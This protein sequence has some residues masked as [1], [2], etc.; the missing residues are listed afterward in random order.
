MSYWGHQC[1]TSA[2]L[3]ARGC[4][5]RGAFIFLIRSVVLVADKQQISNMQAFKIYV[6]S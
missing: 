1:A 5:K 3:G 6:A 4:K 2:S